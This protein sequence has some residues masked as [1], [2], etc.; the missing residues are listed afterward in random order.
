MQ[1]QQNTWTNALKSWFG[2]YSTPIAEAQMNVLN[3]YDEVMTFQITVDET[4]NAMQAV[5]DTGLGHTVIETTA[6]ADCA[7][8]KIDTASG[9]GGLTASA[10]AVSGNLAQSTYSGV[11]GTTTLC[12]YEDAA[13]A[14]APTSVNIGSMPCTQD[15]KVHFAN[16]V[17]TPSKKATA[18]LGMALGKGKDRYGKQPDTTEL[19]MNQFETAT[20]LDADSKKFGLS[21]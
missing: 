13:Y 12:I 11:S 18:Y 3:F 17:A 21:L 7:S 10:T 5:V 16:S 19:L 20:K 15:T 14:N 1:R 4:P 2:L 9:A 6:C 8:G